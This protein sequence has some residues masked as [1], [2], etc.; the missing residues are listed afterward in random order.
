MGTH[1]SHKLKGVAESFI[2]DTI[3]YSATNMGQ[4]PNRQ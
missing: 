3:K 2:K 1:G 4:V